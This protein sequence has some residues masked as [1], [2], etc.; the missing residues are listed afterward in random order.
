M[1]PRAGGWARIWDLPTR[2]FHWLLLVAVAFE[3][4]TGL[5]GPKW[6]VGRHIWVGYGI[7]V[8]LVFRLVWA[9]L[10]S[11]FSRLR[12]FTY[13]PQQVIEHLRAMA[14]GEPRHY[15]GHNPAGAMMIFALLLS[16]ATL[17]VT[18]LFV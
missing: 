7:A 4:V 2:L 18:G 3:I 17:V 11:G 8:L 13:S 1:T 9:F 16:L 10:G 6:W 12:S 15:L 5:A 14:R